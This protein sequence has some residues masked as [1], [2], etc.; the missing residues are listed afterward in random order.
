M[1]AQLASEQTFHGTKDYLALGA[2]LSYGEE[3]PVRGRIL[4]VDII[5]VVP[6]PGKPLTRHKVKTVF[7]G[8]QKGPITALASC[9]GYLIS[10]VGQKVRQSNIT[11]MPTYNLA[12]IHHVNLSAIRNLTFCLL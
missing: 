11:Y 2:N 1:T 9:Q 5:E 8:D 4:L 6:E 7:D 3:I 12:S 10:A